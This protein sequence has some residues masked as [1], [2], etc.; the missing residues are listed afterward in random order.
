MTTRILVSTTTY[1]PDLGGVAVSAARIV[2][3][4]VSAGLAVHVV[5]PRDEPGASGRVSRSE[6]GGA[7]IHRLHHE[8]STSP[9]AGLDLHRL[10]RDLDDEFG[11]DLFYAVFLLSAYPCLTVARRGGRSRPVIA[12][13]QGGDATTLLDFPP[14][15]RMI[16][17]V[18]RKAT[19]IVSVN[20][21]Y[22]ER[23]GRWV[24]VRDRSTVIPTAVAPPR[25]QS[26]WSL[27]GVNRGVVGSVGVFRRV[28]D[29]PLLVRGYAAVPAGR[30][31]GLLLAG[32][33]DGDPEEEEWTRT[34]VD[35]FGIADQ[36]EVTGRFPQ[37]EV[38]AHLRRMHVYV[39]SSSEEG[40]PNSLLEAA[41]LGIPLVA[42]AVGGMAEVIEDGASGLLVPH[43]DPRR[44][45][46]AIAR[47]LA[48][49]DLARRLSAGAR[50]MAE[51]LSP[52]RERREWLGLFQAVLRDF[53]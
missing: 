3:S 44:L 6:E 43:G 35:E 23:V 24:D 1:P 38:F 46:D 45:G 36:V 41:I 53:P 2:D 9:E 17:E 7:T 14:C 51:N 52:D 25:G 47:I 34:L 42:T 26:G 33:F 40:L 16:L 27:S 11:F 10:V 49:D 22:L 21:L 5:V 29:I 31:R 28:K 19:W 13:I 20:H 48:D 50:R 12:G 39:Q 32:V 15:R 30:R 4:L 8:T 18:L 37:P